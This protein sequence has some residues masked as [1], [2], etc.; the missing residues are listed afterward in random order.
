L[1]ALS[2][3]LGS[4]ARSVPLTRE[5]LAKLRRKAWRRGVWFRDLKQSE[6]KLL[7]LTIRVVERVRS[8]MLA[9]LVVRIVDKLCEALESRVYRLIR[10]EGRK[11]AEQLSKI[12]EGWGNRS[13]GSWAGDWGFMQFLTVCSL[14]SLG[15]S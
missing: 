15:A 8:F 9:R 13:A 12:G 2:R 7:S 6:R 10:T 11:M 4:S 5:N 3:R 1:S 14:G